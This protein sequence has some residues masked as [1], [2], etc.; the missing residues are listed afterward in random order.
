MIAIPFWVAP[1]EPM[2]AEAIELACDG[3]RR[4]DA[5]DTMIVRLDDAD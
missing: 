3:D 4:V 1:L 2:S 5:S